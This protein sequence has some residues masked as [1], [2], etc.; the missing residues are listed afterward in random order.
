MA[1]AK[2]RV[3]S[4]FEKRG[5]RA[6]RERDAEPDGRMRREAEGVEQG[7]GMAVVDPWALLLEKLPEPAG[8]DAPS[9]GQGGRQE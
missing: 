4:A 5:R 8:E 6:R 2:E 7:R 3:A 9:A 1:Y